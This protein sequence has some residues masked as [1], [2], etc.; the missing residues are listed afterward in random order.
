VRRLTSS[1]PFGVAFFVAGVLVFALLPQFVAT[2][3][4][5]RLVEV[6]IYLIAAIGLNVV[7]GYS[8]QIS[9]GHGAFMGIGAY[10]TA[11]LVTKYHVGDVW[12]LPVAAAVAG[13]AGF[14]FGFPALRLHGVYLALAT[15]GLAVSFIQVAQSSWPWLQKYTGGGGGLQVGL[16]KTPYYL[17]WGIAAGAF[18]VGWVLMRGRLGR[19]LRAVRDAPLAATSSG[20]NLAT[21]KTLAFGIAAA[22]AG[23]AGGLLAILIGFINAQ[24][25]PVDLSIRL[26]VATAIGGFGSLGGVV[27][28]ALF[29]VY[30]P[31]Y[32]EK[33]SNQAPSVIYGLILLAVLFVMPGGAAQLGRRTLAFARSRLVRELAP[34]AASRPASR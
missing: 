7:T 10:T 3:A 14:L 8:G 27:F 1:P 25:F 5:P 33:I 9:L 17:T 2:T 21:Y 29:I 15:F 30:A 18:L 12:T 6:G 19:S 28:G 23:L 13:I 26:L 20:L 22:Y 16:P 11:I 24:T 32:G 4:Q 31:I 34:D